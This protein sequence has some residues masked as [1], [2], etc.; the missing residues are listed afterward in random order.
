MDLDVVRVVKNGEKNIRGVAYLR[1]LLYR[2][3]QSALR[4]W[5]STF[6]FEKQP[7]DLVGFA[8][9]NTGTQNSSDDIPG[10]RIL[11][12]VGYHIPA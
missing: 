1:I 2:S 4:P 7:I 10:T 9:K 5:M 12:D 6:S 11:A 8:G 3:R